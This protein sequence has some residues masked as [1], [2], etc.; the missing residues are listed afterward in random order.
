MPIENSAGK[1]FDIV[2]FGTIKR[3]AVKVNQSV[4]VLFSNGTTI[5]APVKGIIKNQTKVDNTKQGEKVGIVLGGVWH[6]RFDTAVSVSSSS[7]A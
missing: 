5:T 3:G 1:D 2:L 7:L 6:Q 4:E